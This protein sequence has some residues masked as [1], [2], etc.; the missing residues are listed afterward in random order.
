M[1]VLDTGSTTRPTYNKSSN[2]LTGTRQANSLERVSFYG[3]FLSLI[4]ALVA[5]VPVIGKVYP[6]DIFLV[7]LLLLWG[8]RSITNKHRDTTAIRKQLTATDITL[9]LLFIFT[10]ITSL[11]GLNYANSKNSL[12]LLGRGGL[13]YFY[14]R[15][16]FGST[17]R[18]RDLRRIIVIL[19]GIEAVVCLL[20]SATQSF[21]GAINNY[22]G[23]AAWEVSS[24]FQMG[25]STIIRAV[26]TFQSP[27]IP[28]DWFVLLSPL[29]YSWFSLKVVRKPIRYLALWLL[30]MVALI[31][32]FARAAWGGTIIALFTLNRLLPKHSTKSGPKQNSFLKAG[33]LC[34]FL[35]ILVLIAL[36]QAEVY[37]QNPIVER[38]NTTDPEGRLIY[39]DAAL[40]LIRQHPLL[41]IGM[42]NFRE[43]LFGPIGDALDIPAWFY[44]RTRGAGVHN[45][46]LLFAVEAGIASG[47][48]FF[49][50]VFNVIRSLW[51]SL[52]ANRNAETTALSIGLLA[53]LIGFATTMLFELGFTHPSIQIMF[54]ALTGV[55]TTLA[56][57]ARTES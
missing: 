3:L 29:L 40:Q 48:L 46:Y 43:A 53:G 36:F 52:H 11:F 50:F 22:F 12:L 2:A 38:L 42:G 17:V 15:A 21:V 4:A 28:S 47:F 35:A 31:T 5:Y 30:C 32:T 34:I 8:L 26:G 18:I 1:T 9:I 23:A 57:Q 27:A 19:L 44:R 7:P 14:M 24:T 33:L 37:I 49:V 55:A 41:G 39:I 6:F 20:Q 51:R 25:G 54:F 16:N 13:I 56:A 10:F 45:I